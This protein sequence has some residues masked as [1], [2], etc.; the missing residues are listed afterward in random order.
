MVQSLQLTLR[1]EAQ[2]L[3]LTYRVKPAK[4]PVHTSAATLQLLQLGLRA[5]L[6]QRPLA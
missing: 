6:Q 3:P 2:H 5:V 4:Q 1:V